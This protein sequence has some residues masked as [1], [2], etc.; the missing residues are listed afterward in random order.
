MGFIEDEPKDGCHCLILVDAMVLVMI[1]HLETLGSLAKQL[2]VS[3]QAAVTVNSTNVCW[4]F[5]KNCSPSHLAYIFAT[6]THTR[7]WADRVLWI[8]VIIQ[9][10]SI[11]SSLTIGAECF[12]R[13][14]H[15]RMYN[16]L[17]RAKC[18]GEHYLGLNNLAPV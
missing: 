6:S 3:A 10:A 5:G 11:G 12:P 1:M 14:V 18:R 7:H 16:M 15:Q 2:L 9:C 8:E 13:I 17:M 4:T